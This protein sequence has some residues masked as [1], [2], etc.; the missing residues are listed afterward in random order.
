MY[1]RALTRA[2][3]GE[4]ASCNFPPPWRAIRSRFGAFSN[5]GYRDEHANYSEFALRFTEDQHL[6]QSLSRKGSVTKRYTFNGGL[7]RYEKGG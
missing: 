2:R 3:L 6:A 1:C 4:W 7:G 5:N